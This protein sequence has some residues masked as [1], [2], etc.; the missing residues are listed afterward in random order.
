MNS[1]PLE[2][3][4]EIRDKAKEMGLDTEYWVVDTI[5]RMWQARTFEV[6]DD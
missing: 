6:R 1:I 3:L 5:I 2:W 4:I